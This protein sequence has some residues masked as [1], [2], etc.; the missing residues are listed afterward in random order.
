MPK[1]NRPRFGSLQFWPRKRAEKEIPS[2]NW[3]T[4]KGKGILGFITYKVGM[5]TE[6]GRAHV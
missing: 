3:K 6:I 4:I 1:I 5:A 2:V